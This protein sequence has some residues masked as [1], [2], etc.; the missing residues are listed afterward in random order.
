MLKRLFLVGH[1]GE[2]ERRDYFERLFLDERWKGWDVVFLDHT[3]RPKGPIREDYLPAFYHLYQNYIR[4][5]RWLF[6]SGLKMFALCPRA[7][8]ESMAL[9][10]YVARV[11]SEYRLGR[12]RAIVDVVCGYCV[13]AVKL[14]YG[15]SLGIELRRGDCVVLFGSNQPSQ[16]L[17]RAY[18]RKAK[19]RIVFAEH[20]SLSGTLHFNSESVTFGL[21]PMRCRERFLAAPLEKGDIEKGRNYLQSIAQGKRDQKPQEVDEALLAKIERCQGKVLF[22]PA[23]GEIGGGLYP[24]NGVESKKY[25]LGFVRIRI[26]LRQFLEALEKRVGPWFT[27]LIRIQF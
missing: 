14:L 23:N 18:C 5:K 13:V 26:C 6:R 11:K 4:D 7:S 27:S 17:L 22:L 12:L 2:L 21:F 15:R 1:W 8:L 3:H 10:L 24:S 16:R 20:G 25:L 9:D 19:I